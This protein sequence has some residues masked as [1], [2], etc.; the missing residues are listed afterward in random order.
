MLTER[1]HFILL[2]KSAGVLVQV[3]NAVHAVGASNCI[4]VISKGTPR[5]GMTN[6]TKGRIYAD[7]D[8]GDDDYLVKEI[9][10]LAQDIPDLTIIP[11][12]CPAERMM[13]RI[14]HRL[15]A[16]LIPAPNTVMLDLF[17]NKWR[18]YQFCKE[19]GLNVPST[20]LID[21]KHDLDFA[22]AAY[23]F[24]LPFVIKPVD[25]AGSAGFQVISSEQEYHKK[26]LHD[27]RYQ[28]SPLLVQQY[29][30]GPDISLNLLAI[31]GRIT[32]ISI[33]QRDV[34]QNFGAPI[35]FISNPWLETAAYTMC[36]ATGYHGVMCIDARVEKKTNRVF[37][38]ESNPRFWGSLSASVW[39]GLN[40]VQAC[41]EPAPPASQ[42]RRLHSGRASVHYHPIV[43][44]TLWGPALFSEHAH[45]RRMLRVMMADL[46]TFLVQIESLRQ[47]VQ[48]YLS[49]QFR[50][51]LRSA[52]ES[53]CQRFVKLRKGGKNESDTESKV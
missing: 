23:E 13:D 18:F 17:D 53:G 6:M 35:E 50:F 27:D 33:Q 11:C 26:I 49:A 34:P 20:R 3:L 4:V 15:N 46:W 19:Y 39:C 8:G 1:K 22:E 48:K 2:S 45:Q 10:N 16:V 29:V 31:H 25:Q 52:E 43:R 51:F 21:S 5:F 38:F 37:L 41:M 7:F 30:E 47:K 40:F 28:F 32:A 44:P 24:G 36:E 42:I 14:G 12:D 9:N